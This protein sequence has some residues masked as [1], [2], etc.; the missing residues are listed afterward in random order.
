MDVNA[1]QL[2]STFIIAF[3]GILLGYTVG[4]AKGQQKSDKGVL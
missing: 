3:T 4:V 1:I 2:I